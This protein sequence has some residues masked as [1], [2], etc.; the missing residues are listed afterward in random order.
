MLKGRRRVEADRFVALRSHYLFESAFT[1]T[2]KKGAHEKGG[3]EGEVGRFRRAHLV[4]VPEVG[5]LR[6]LN[7]L[8]AVACVADLRR[9][10]RGRP[11]TVGEA[12][13]REVEL[14]RPLPREQF[15]AAETASPRVD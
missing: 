14:L 11:E 15:D 2:G 7:E 12:L 9:T 4:P 3:V 5:S 6:E 8:L 1:R 10:I 13:A